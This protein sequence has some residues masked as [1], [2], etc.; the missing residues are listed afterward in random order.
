MRWEEGHESPDV[1]DRRGRGGGG[2]GG[3]VA[4]LPFLLRSRGGVIVLL[5]LL[6]FVALSSLGKW[7][8]LFGASDEV[9]TSSVRS[10]DKKAQFVAFVLD[11]VQDTWKKEFAA[12]GA[13]YRNAKLVMFTDATPTACGQGQAATGPFYCPADERV[14]IDLSFYDEL[15]RRFGAKGDFAQAYVIGHE[16]G[17]HVQNLL[18]V[19]EAV[20]AAKRSEQKGATGLDV[21]LELQADCFAGVWAHATEQRGLLEAGDID[22]ALG[23]ASAIGDDRMQRMAGR[24]VNPE[25]WT[26]GS[27]AQ[28]SRWFKK[29]FESG[30]PASCDTFGAAV[31]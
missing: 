25:S 23:A 12:R 4:L 6:A 30:D 29:G 2:M 27:A 3:I 22:E 17:H 13:T 10:D 21:R 15:E 31:L 28:R 11:D 19:S 16:I 18:G 1:I 5:A 20:H 9:Q 14:Y 24:A 26:H 7:S 8:G